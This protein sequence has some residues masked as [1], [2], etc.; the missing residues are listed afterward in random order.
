MNI[1]HYILAV[2]PVAGSFR[3]PARS[4]LTVGVWVLDSFGALL[5]AVHYKGTV[6]VG[7]AR[8]LQPPLPQSEH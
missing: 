1:S 4:T 3:G 2:P 7:F 5:L 6:R 8:G